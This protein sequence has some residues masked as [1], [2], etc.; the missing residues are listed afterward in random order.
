MARA[1][2]YGLGPWGSS[3]LANVTRKTSTSDGICSHSVASCQ[4]PSMMRCGCHPP[5]PL[6]NDAGIVGDIA[7]STS[8]L[9]R[10]LTTPSSL[11]ALV[12]ALFCPLS[13]RSGSA[14]STLSPSPS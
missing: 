4:P 12:I 14:L 6:D 13:S 2:P 11:L 3:A 8:N 10:L 7:A 5:D 1:L 9:P